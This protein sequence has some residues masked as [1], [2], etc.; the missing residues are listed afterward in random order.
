VYPED[1]TQFCKISFLAPA[2]TNALNLKVEADA[3]SKSHKSQRW[4]SFIMP[5]LFAPTSKA[6]RHRHVEWVIST[7]LLTG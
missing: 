5:C 6:G 2:A 7:D 3:T 4:P 1:L